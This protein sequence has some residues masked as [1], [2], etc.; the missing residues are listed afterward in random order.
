MPLFSLP[1]LQERAADTSAAQPS[2]APETLVLLQDAL[3]IMF[4]RWRWEP[5][6]DGEWDELQDL[7]ANATDELYT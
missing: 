2:M 6:T 1:S 3:A 7:L 5:M 4:D